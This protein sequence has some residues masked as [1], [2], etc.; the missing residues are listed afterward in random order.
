MMKRIATPVPIAGGLAR[1]EAQVKRDLALLGFPAKPWLHPRTINA[2]EPV[3]DVAIIGA[4]MN[5]IAAASAL[6]AKGIVN[7]RVFDA[8]EPGREGPWN[9]Y[10]RMDTLRSPKTLTG[11]ALGIPSLTFAAWYMASFGEA[12]WEALYKIPNAVWVDYLGWLQ[13]VLD[14]PV[15]HRT[16]LS[17]LR[18]HDGLLAL[19]IETA[20]GAKTVFARHVVLATGRGGAG[21]DV[22]PDIVPLA[23]K[24]AFAAHSNDPID[25][26]KLR[27]KSVGV[28]GGSAS[29]WD[30]AATALE[31]GAASAAMY[32]RRP[33]LPQ[34]NKGRGSANP[35]YFHGWGALPDAERWALAAYLDDRLAPP[36]HETVLRALRSD[37]L[38]IR[39]RHSVA[40]VRREGEQVVLDI[41]TPEGRIERRHDFL[42]VATGFQVDAASITELVDFAPHVARWSDRYTPPTGLAR[43]ALARAP[44]LGPGFEL[45]PRGA[46]APAELSRI[47]LVNH[48]ALVSHGAIASDIPG[49]AI[50]GERVAQA[51]VARFFRQDIAEVRRDLEAFDEP[52]L[53]D[54][55]FFK[56]E[57]FPHS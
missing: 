2:S 35:G 5:G 54:T 34:I 20:E 43:P 48:G 44:Y 46:D 22:W 18:P 50:A 16:T 11:P 9:R 14:L 8:N 1:H 12:A 27:G 4:G 3:L 13:R 56:P 32:L 17:K 41:D 36:P 52:E 19:D 49:V 40:A 47:H 29:A 24:P 30:N 39:F 10:A 42:V 7:I 21:G 55:P 38:D 51:L 31:R 25:F 57:D 15:Q 53:K 23:L 28:I 37:G 26:D 6:L 33:H 45:Q